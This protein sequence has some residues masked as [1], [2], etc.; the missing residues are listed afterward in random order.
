MKRRWSLR[1]RI[2]GAYVLLA[3]FLGTCFSAI[4]LEA[5]EIIEDKFYGTSGCR[6]RPD[7]LIEAH[8]RAGT[9][10]PGYPVVLQEAQLTPVLASWTRGVQR[11]AGQA[12]RDVHVLIRDRRSAKR[13]S[14]CLDEPETSSSSSEKPMCRSRSARSPF[15]PVSSRWAAPVRP[16]APRGASHRARVTRLGERRWKR[17][18]LRA[19][20]TPPGG[21]TTQVG[22]WHGPSSTTMQGQKAHFSRRDQLF[23]GDVSATKLRTPLDGVVMLGPPPRCWRRALFR[24]SRSLLEIAERIGAPPPRLRGETPPAAA[25]PGADQN[26]RAAH[27]RRADRAGRS[28]KR[29]PPPPRAGKPVT[30]RRF[31]GEHAGVLVRDARPELVR[32]LRWAT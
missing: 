18:S 9:R 13:I 14:P 30:L 20:F 27:R 5:L 28:G 12:G 1:R 7:K 29:C 32:H 24:Q 10:H 31:G 25:R 16:E 21:R 8:L 6:M 17:E 2:V 22:C 15:R 19:G 26:G 23:T 4:A 3:L 11:G